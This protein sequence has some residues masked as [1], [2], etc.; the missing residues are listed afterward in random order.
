MDASILVVGMF[1]NQKIVL[2]LILIIV[3]FLFL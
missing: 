1:L 2:N 3:M